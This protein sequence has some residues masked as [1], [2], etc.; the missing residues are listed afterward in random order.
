MY[1]DV[2]LLNS[3]NT[4]FCKEKTPKARVACGVKELK[5]KGGLSLL[6]G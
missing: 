5:E 4:I 2:V 1:F 6:T 3:S